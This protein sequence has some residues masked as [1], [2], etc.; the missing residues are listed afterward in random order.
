MPVFLPVKC[1][2]VA[3]KQEEAEDSAVLIEFRSWFGLQLSILRTYFEISGV[4][5]TLFFVGA[6]H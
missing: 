6:M 2:S 1:H 3:D 5:L 4:Q